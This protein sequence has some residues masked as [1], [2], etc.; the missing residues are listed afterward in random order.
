MSRKGNE[1]M[2]VKKLALVIAG[3]VVF[4][5]AV[6]IVEDLVDRDHGETYEEP[7]AAGAVSLPGSDAAANQAQ[8]APAPESAAATGAAAG[9]V[10]A[11]QASAIALAEVP[12]TV[13]DVWPGEE[14]GRAVWYVDVRA[15]DGRMLEVYVDATTGEVLDV[16]RD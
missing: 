11:E 13:V 16:E 1:E 15:E 10:D 8:P 14:G 5:A 6:Y 9:G 4:G 7:A 12:G 3:V 2:N